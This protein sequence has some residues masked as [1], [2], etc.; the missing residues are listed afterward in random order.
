[1]KMKIVLSMAALSMFAF[2]TIAQRGEGKKKDWNP[3]KRVEAKVERFASENEMTDAQKEALK[4]SLMEHHKEMK[5]VREAEKERKKEMWKEHKAQKDEKVKSAL[6]DE[7]LLEAW[8][9]FEKAQR[10]ERKKKMKQHR[11][12]KNRGEG[13]RKRTNEHP[14]R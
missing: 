13:H 1:M 10:A 9:E 3:E 5:S 14:N 2:A 12:N 8:K 4:Q 7:N 6:N 11:K